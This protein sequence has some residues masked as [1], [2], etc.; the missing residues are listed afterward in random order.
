MTWINLNQLST[1]TQDKS[2]SCWS[3]VLTLKF[4]HT[5]CQDVNFMN[6]YQLAVSRMAGPPNMSCV[7][8]WH[9][10]WLYL[11]AHFSESWP[12]KGNKNGNS[13]RSCKGQRSRPFRLEIENN[14]FCI[15]LSEVELQSVTTLD[16]TVQMDCLSYQGDLKTSE[17]QGQTDEACQTGPQLDHSFQP[18]LTP[19]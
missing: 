10:V 12:H 2:H 14:T 8:N 13:R 16:R 1:G 11:C 17:L 18:Q 5:L 6:W 9:V 4:M 7:S 19:V 3:Y 15:M